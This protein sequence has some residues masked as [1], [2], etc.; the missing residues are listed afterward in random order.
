MFNMIS[1]VVPTYNEAEN[2]PE[3]LERLDRAL[4]GR[5]YEVVVVDDGSPDGTAEVAKRLS[6]RYP[7]RVLVREGRRGLS[8]AVVEG[9]RAAAGSVVV[10]MDADLQHPPELVPKL[11]E[12]AERGCLAVASRYVKGGR[13]EGWPWH[14][15]FVSHGAVLLARILLPEARDVKDA[16][17]GFFAVHHDCIASVSPTGL[18]KILLD[19]LVQCRPKCVV[20]I[21]Y[22]F[23]LRTRGHS[24]LGISHIADYLRQ[25]LELRRR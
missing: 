8:S 9:A 21:P 13:V 23:G 10:V 14:R 4:A 19:V 5:D 7:V 6:G 18:Y 12:V 17:S 3:L 22:V 2:L 15:R 25:I 1:V 20:E 11:A 24:K 16:V